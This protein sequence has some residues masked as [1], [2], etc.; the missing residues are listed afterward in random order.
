MI[1][2]RILL[3]LVFALPILTVVFGILMGAY[4]VTQSMQDLVG[5]RSLWL[6]VRRPL[7]L[8][9]NVLLLVFAL[10]I[11]AIVEPPRER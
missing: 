6:A 8:V 9:A 5:S 11:N 4:A 3:V 2:K 7:L 1:S 10:G